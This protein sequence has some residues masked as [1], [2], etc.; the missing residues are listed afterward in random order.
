MLS[1]NNHNNHQRTKQNKKEII[2]EVDY[3]SSG[4]KGDM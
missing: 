1:S 3:G 2:E 4:H